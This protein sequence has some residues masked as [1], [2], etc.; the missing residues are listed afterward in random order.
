MEFRKI[1]NNENFKKVWGALKGEELVTSPMGFSKDDPNIDLIRK[2][3]Y[4]FSIK[5]PNKEVL[6]TTFANKITTSFR[7]ISPFFDYMSNVLTTD[8]NGESILK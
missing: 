1:I 7:S 4:L 8:L 3:M 6:N 2:K 5:Y